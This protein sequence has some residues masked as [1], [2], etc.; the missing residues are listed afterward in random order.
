MMNDRKR[1]KNHFLHDLED[2][3]DFF[4]S[5][6]FTSYLDCDSVRIDLF[7]TSTSYIVEVDLPDFDKD[8]VLIEVF[9]HQLRIQ[10]KK[11]Q[12]VKVEDSTNNSFSAQ[13]DVKLVDR[14]VDFPFSLPNQPMKATLENGVLEITIEKEGKVSPPIST[15]AITEW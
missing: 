7:E 9:E 13:K 3:V 15:L 2:L 1:P 10:A 14:T 12:L 8:H 6:P 11:E 4:F 5:H